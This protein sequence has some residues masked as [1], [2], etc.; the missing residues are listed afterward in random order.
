MVHVLAIVVIQTKKLLYMLDTSGC[1]PFTN[2]RQLG[3]V[4]MD[5]DMANYV[6]QVVY[7]AVKKCIFLYLCKWLVAAKAS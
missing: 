5:L 7:L 4:R 1:E 2:G 3:Q 6:A